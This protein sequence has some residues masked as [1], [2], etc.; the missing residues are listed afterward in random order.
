MDTQEKHELHLQI[1]D[2]IHNVD[3]PSLTLY[4]SPL[5]LYLS[6]ACIMSVFLLNEATGIW[7]G[8]ML[9]FFIWKTWVEIPQLHSGMKERLGASLQTT[10]LSTTVII[11]TEIICY[12]CSNIVE[13]LV[14]IIMQM[15][16][17]AWHFAQ[18]TVLVC[19]NRICAWPQENNCIS[20]WPSWISKWRHLNKG[21]CRNGLYLVW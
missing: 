1:I 15:V 19:Y 7:T 12:C 5:H 4:K 2:Y 9:L 6:L 10:P 8:W 13:L 18:M 3:P 14:T 21:L 17:Q 11:I 20:R 16:I